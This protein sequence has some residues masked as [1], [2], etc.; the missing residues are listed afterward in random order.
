MQDCQV[1]KHCG[2]RTTFQEQHLRI[3]V[4]NCTYKLLEVGDLELGDGEVSGGRVVVLGEHS[5][6]LQ[7][8]V[9]L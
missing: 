9:R 3:H 1:I 4:F 5:Y 8:E 2:L 7:M 6:S